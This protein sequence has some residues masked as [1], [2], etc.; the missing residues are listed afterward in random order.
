MAKYRMRT[1]LFSIG[2]DY[3]IENDNGDNVFKVDGKKMR[4]RKTFI[5]ENRNGQEVAKIVEKK[6]SIRDAIRIERNGDTVATVRKKMISGPFR[7][8]YVINLKDGED[9]KAKGSILDHEYK[10]ERDG[11]K[12]AECSKSWFRVRDTYG[13][14]I[15]PGEDDALI[16]AAC[17]CLEEL[18]SGDVD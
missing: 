3:W 2:D 7:D 18:G 11:K 13:I 1:K 5:L 10:I 15:E 6:L 8:K 9:L 17:V 4:V 16:L 12:V 14:E